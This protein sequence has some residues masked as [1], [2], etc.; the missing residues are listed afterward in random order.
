MGF[1]YSRMLYSD[2]A[3]SQNT[4]RSFLCLEDFCKWYTD[5]EAKRPIIQPQIYK[6]RI[7]SHS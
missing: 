5:D 2:F 3:N 1:Y 6:S 4:S 7:T